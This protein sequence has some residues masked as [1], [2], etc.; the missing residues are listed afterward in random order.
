VKEPE[1]QK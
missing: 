1:E